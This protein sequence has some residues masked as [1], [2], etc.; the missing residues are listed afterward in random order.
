MKILNNIRT[1]VWS[2]V[3]IAL[4]GYLLAT[5]ATS[6]SN[7]RITDSL[8]RLEAIHFPLALKGGKIFTLFNEQTMHFEGGLITGETDELAKAREHHEEISSLLN[9]MVQMASSQDMSFYSQLLTLRDAYE[10]YFNL[11]ADQ[12]M[13]MSQRTDIFEHTQLLLRIGKVRERLLVKFKEITGQLTETV[14]NEIKNNKQRAAGNSRLLHLLFIAVLLIATLAINLL[15]N[16]QLITPLKNLKEL[17]DNF[18]RGKTVEKPQICDSADEICS[19]ALSFWGMTEELKKIS[20]SRNYL[21]NIINYM[22]DCLLVLSPT[23]SITRVNQSALNLLSYHEEELLN[24]PANHIF[25]EYGTGATIQTI[26]EELLQGKSITNLEMMLR[27]RDNILISVLFSGTTFYSTSGTVEG[28]VC[29]ARDIR[30]LKGNLDNRESMSNFDPLTHLPNHNLLHDRLEH[31]LRLAKRSQKLSA[32]L[33]IYL[34]LSS[35]II[36]A[37]DDTGKLILQ[38]A[39][40]RFLQSVRETDTVARMKRNQ[41][42]IILTNLND[43]QDAKLV[44]G[45]IMQEFHLPFHIF[46]SGDLILSIGITLFPSDGSNGSTLLRNADTAL[47]EAKKQGGNFYSFYTSTMPTTQTDINSI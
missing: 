22:S 36:D 25:S 20:V 34:D 9:E 39:A 5:I 29:L 14:V 35:A 43:Q 47:T 41:F 11:A 38:E 8:T 42:A 23:L 27:T 32:L 21:D 6:I 17:I 12:Y 18:G 31:T 7:I 28:V 40:K 13:Q 16:R 19:L 33:L 46:G 2:C 10:D 44:A 37:G 30:E 4:L 24:Q 1:K 26:F 45:K 15:A 3:A